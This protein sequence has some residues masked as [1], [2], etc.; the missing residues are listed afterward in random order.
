M[1]SR[2][3]LL[4]ALVACAACD[5]PRAQPHP[6]LWTLFDLQ[7]L[8]ARSGDSAPVLAPEGGVPDGLPLSHF[9]TRSGTELWLGKTFTDGYVSGYVTTELWS[10]WDA[11]W[12]QPAYVP[13][14]GWQASGAPQK[15]LGDDKAWHP[16]FSVGPRSAFYSPYW[17]VVYFEVPADTPPDRYTSA[18]QVLDGGFPLHPAEGHVLSLA[19]GPLGPPTNDTGK[20]PLPIGNIKQ[21]SGW[22][23][24]Q[25]IAFLDFGANTFQWNERREVQETPLFMF[26]MRNADGVLHTLDVPTVGGAGRIGS[27]TPPRLAADGTPLYGSFWR[28]Y[29]VELPA[30]AR[31]FAPAAYSDIEGA[32]DARG[33]PTVGTYADAVSSMATPADVAQIAPI[34][35]R[36]ALDAACFDTVEHIQ[37]TR[38]GGTCQWL[39]SQAAIERYIEPA[40]VRRTE[41][42]VTCP[43][44]NYREQAV[45]R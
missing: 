13:V 9:L 19:P 40:S 29:T 14:V 45:A 36:V 33:L 43:F 6:R 17:Q 8:G 1:M 3:S 10:G 18:R 28:L 7:A 41:L 12:V 16:I 31:V 24:G 27:A 4:L 23:D 32:L 2:A 37:P 30:T 21:L 39:D 26:T 15:L 20:L 25:P 34:V 42:L 38:E 11:V 22:L 5:L 35:G 44:V